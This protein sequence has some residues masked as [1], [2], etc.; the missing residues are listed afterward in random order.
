MIEQSG[1]ERNHSIRFVSRGDHANTD[2]WSLTGMRVA[3]LSAPIGRDES[4]NRGTARS[5]IL[6][7]FRK[8]DGGE[9]ETKLNCGDMVS[10]SLMGSADGR[11]RARWGLATGIIK[12]IDAVEVT[13]QLQDRLEHVD[14]ARLLRLDKE[15]IMTSFGTCRNNIL[16]L[17]S[18]HV[19]L[20][21]T[22]HQHGIAQC[23]NR[24][25][26]LMATPSLMSRWSTTL[27][28]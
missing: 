28:A 27:A 19:R 2:G 3:N 12:T 14:E 22:S 18:P 17:L 24:L 8:A 7:H 25:L 6:H 4:V 9:L 26:E 20:L 23:F 16:S 5:P 15:E 10:V 13:V 21:P 11:V 1:A